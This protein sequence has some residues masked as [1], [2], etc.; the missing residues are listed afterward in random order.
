MAHGK[1]STWAAFSKAET[2]SSMTGKL[3]IYGRYR[4]CGIDV[5]GLHRTSFNYNAFQKY[6]GRKVKN[7]ATAVHLRNCD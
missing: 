7:F 6:W 1:F 5:N 2:Q 3:M 4:N